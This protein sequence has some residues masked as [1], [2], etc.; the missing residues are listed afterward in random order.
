MVEDMDLMMKVI[1]VGNG[2]VGKTCLITRFVKDRFSMDYKKTL[3]VDY[4][5]KQMFVD[6]EEVTYHVWDTA[7]QE[8]FNALTRRYY[9]GAS[10]C[11]LAFATNNR[12]SFEAVRRWRD[13]VHNECG[14]EIT[15]VLIQ[16]KIDLIDEAEVNEQEAEALATE[17]DIPLIR[18]CSKDNVMVKE[19]FQHLASTYF[20]NKKQLEDDFSSP[21][22]SIEELKINRGFGFGGNRKQA[23]NVNG[24]Q[25]AI[26]VG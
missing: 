8:E 13:A 2:Q 4:L 6:G 14:E 9:R 5:Q 1:I 18:V 15:M 21:I 17:F 22:T 7:G 24:C 16:T 26:T 11:V 20:G 12:D 25:T 3:G 23:Q 19:V 10:A